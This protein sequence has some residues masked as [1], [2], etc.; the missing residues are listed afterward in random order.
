MRRAQ[1]YETASPSGRAAAAP[2]AGS[3]GGKVVHARRWGLILGLVGGGILALAG[4]IVLL[5]DIAAL[6]AGAGG[7]FF[8][9]ALAVGIL[10]GVFSFL[11]FVFSAVGALPSLWVTRIMGVALVVIGIVLIVVVVGT[12]GAITFFGI[13]PL[14]GSILAVVAGGVYVAAPRPPPSSFA[15]RLRLRFRPAR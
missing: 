5:G 13:L 11:A 7:R 8:A 15:R 10:T 3:T 9:N 2:T 12:V 4:I 6:A 14:A 1:R